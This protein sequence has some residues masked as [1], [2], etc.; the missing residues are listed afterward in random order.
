[1]R[2][3]VVQVETPTGPVDSCVVDLLARRQPAEGPLTTPIEVRGH[4]WEQDCN[5]KRH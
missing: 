3:R 1:M 5:D 2:E 4:A